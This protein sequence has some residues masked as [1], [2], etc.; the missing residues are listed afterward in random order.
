MLPKKDAGQK[1]I[2]RM[3]QLGSA[4]VARDFFILRLHATRPARPPRRGA[5]DSK[6]RVYYRHRKAQGCHWPIASER[7]GLESP[8]LSL[9]WS[10][11]VDQCYQS[12][13]SGIG[14]G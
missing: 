3:L 5:F 6:E 10:R 14:A 9:P 13:Y 1:K 2:G 12:V 4:L 11:S 8:R 7:P